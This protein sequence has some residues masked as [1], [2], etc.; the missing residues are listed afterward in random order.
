MAQVCTRCVMD[1]SDSQI[2]FDKDGVCNHCHK[3]DQVQSQ[4]LFADGSG[5]Q[6]LE[7]IVA[8]IKRDGAGTVSY[9]HLRAHET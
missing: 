6:R 9:T 8:Q 3:F 1:T 5:S 7:S 4:Q 2:V